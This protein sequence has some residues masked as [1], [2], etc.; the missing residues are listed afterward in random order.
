MS[1]KNKSNMVAVSTKGIHALSI[2]LVIEY[3]EGDT[4]V[5][6]AFDVVVETDKRDKTI[7]NS[8]IP[9]FFF[10]FFPGLQIEFMS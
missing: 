8:L 7:Q 1:A 9:F 10:S 5:S 2:I 6:W 4:I 3:I